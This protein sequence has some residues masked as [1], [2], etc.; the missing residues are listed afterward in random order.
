[1]LIV[2]HF[3]A[4]YPNYPTFWNFSI[5]QLSFETFMCDWTVFHDFSRY[6][7]LKKD[8]QRLSVL[9]NKGHKVEAKPARPVTVYNLGLREFTPPH[10]T[11]GSYATLDISIEQNF[12]C[13]IL[14][15]VIFLFRCWVWWGILCQKLGRWSGKRWEGKKKIC[16]NL[17]IMGVY[18]CSSFIMCSCKGADS[19][20]TGSIYSGT[21][22]F[23]WRAL[24][25]WT[26]NALIAAMLRARQRL[27][28]GKVY[29]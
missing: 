2:H 19:D 20:Q 17:K 18:F 5:V 24:D 21:A 13:N 28:F 11:L 1:M 12:Y 29:K 3:L 15:L 7:A 27:L 25:A 26:Y 9:L 14:I 23:A 10:F 22:C 16:I 6:S 4:N 8:G